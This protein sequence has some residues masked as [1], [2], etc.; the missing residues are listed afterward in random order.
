M[1]YR[2]MKR[3]MRGD[4]GVDT[5]KE[6]AAR[7]REKMIR[8]GMRPIQIWAPDTRAPAFAEECRR[9]SMM[10]ANDDQERDILTFIEDSADTEGWK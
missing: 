6:R 8:A 7:H 3:I 2:Y 9:Q 4:I 5:T 1:K 10:L